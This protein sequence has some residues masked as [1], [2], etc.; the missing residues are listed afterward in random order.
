M[1][2]FEPDPNV[3]VIA[4]LLKLLFH[5]YCEPNTLLSPPA[6][7][8]GA[9]VAAR[10]AP[11]ARIK[12]KRDRKDFFLLN[13]DEGVVTAMVIL[14][15]GCFFIGCLNWELIQTVWKERQRPGSG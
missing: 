6:W 2:G 8:A 10:T 9:N 1:L 11:P 4:L 13:A 14:D 12:G 5:A 3:A 7:T 15:S